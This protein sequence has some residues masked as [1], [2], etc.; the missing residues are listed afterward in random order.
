MEMGDD[1]GGEGEE[2]DPDFYPDDL[3]HQGRVTTETRLSDSDLM[4]LNKLLNN[5]LFLI[6][7]PANLSCH[8][9]D[10]HCTLTNGAQEGGAV[11]SEE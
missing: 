5:S 4:N 1:G 8:S 11:G 3:L 2:E 7:N 6:P 9:G 10:G